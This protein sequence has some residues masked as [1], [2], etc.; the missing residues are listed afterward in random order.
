MD[1][2]VYSREVRYRYSPPDSSM[3]YAY[4]TTGHVRL[5]RLSPPTDPVRLRSVTV[6]YNREFTSAQ[7]FADYI[8]EWRQRDNNTK[9]E[10]SPILMTTEGTAHGT[11]TPGTRNPNV[12]A[13]KRVVQSSHS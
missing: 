9:H 8:H 12:E 10:R 13:F 6:L 1:S 3:V 4:F 11:E 5:Y 7:Q 2:S